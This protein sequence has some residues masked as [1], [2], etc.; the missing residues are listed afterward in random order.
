MKTI[1]I[2]TSF[3]NTSNKKDVMER[4]GIT[5]AEY[6][7]IRKLGIP[8]KH[9]SKHSESSFE[10]TIP[11]NVGNNST[12]TVLSNVNETHQNQEKLQVRQIQPNSAYYYPQPMYIQ[13][14]YESAHDHMELS[15][16]FLDIAMTCKQQGSDEEFSHYLSRSR[17]EEDIARYYESMANHQST[18]SCSYSSG[19]VVIETKAVNSTFS[20]I[21]MGIGATNKIV[22]ILAK[23]VDL[24]EQCIKLFGGKGNN[25]ARDSSNTGS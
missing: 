18:T 21:M 1:K 23:L 20:N 2:D 11:D 9:S 13:Q 22:D 17:E 25:E 8:Q 16:K 19:D 14:P 15:R 5:E 7:Y 12:A 4:Y 6:A 24:A 10:V 3:F